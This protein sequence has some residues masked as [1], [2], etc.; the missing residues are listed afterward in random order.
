[1][2]H[3]KRKHPIFLIKKIEEK[4]VFLTKLNIKFG[5]ESCNQNEP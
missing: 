5:S 3:N 1:M 4:K 2:S